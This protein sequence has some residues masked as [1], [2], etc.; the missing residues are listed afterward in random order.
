MPGTHLLA[1][2]AAASLLLAGNPALATAPPASEEAALDSLQGVYARAVAPGEDAALYR[3]LLGTVMQRIKRSSVA[4]VDL[5]ALAAE[6]TK[7]IE[8]L[9]S[10][11]GEPAEVFKRALHGSMRAID[12]HFRYLDA[13]T[14]GTERSDSMGSFSGLGLQV[15]PSGS[16]VRIVAR[17]RAVR[18]SGRACWPAI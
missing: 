1:R 13:R 10:G 8:P 5:A 6:A 15:E 18:P 11:V 16:A 14:Y 2:W 12:P 9:P 4:S 17:S 3:E 7:A